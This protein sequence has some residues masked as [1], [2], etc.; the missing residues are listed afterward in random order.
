MKRSFQTVVCV[1]QNCLLESRS[2][3]VWDASCSASPRCISF[4][5]DAKVSLA[6]SYIRFTLRLN[7]VLTRIL[8]QPQRPVRAFAFQNENAPQNILQAKTIHSR[9]KSSPA[10]TA[11]T[12]SNFQPRPT[13]G[14][15]LAPRR[16]AF[17]DLSN[18]RSVQSSKDDAYLPAKANG[19]IVKPVPTEDASKLAPPM[20]KA[21]QK[22]ATSNTLRG[23]WNTVTGSSAAQRGSRV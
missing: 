15:S 16:A 23:F 19:A 10:L 5:M 22:P 11:F 8:L 4:K 20:Q 13:G 21:A 12:K 3:F 17:A 1:P 9:H 2:T 6:S 14:V 7:Q 18:T